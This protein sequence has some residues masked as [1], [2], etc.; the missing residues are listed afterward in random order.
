MLDCTDL[1]ARPKLVSSAAAAL[2]RGDIAVA[3][4]ENMYTLVCDAFSQR[5][6]DSAR[7]L[8]GNSKQ[9]LSVLVGRPVAVDGVA[10]NIPKYAR[11]LMAAFWPGPLT[12]LLRQ[13]PSL[14]WP[15]RAP[16]LAVRMPLHPLMLELTREVGPTAATSA[17][18]PGSPPISSHSDFED[19]LTDEVDLFLDAGL[20]SL[21]ERS[22]VVDAT[23]GNAPVLKRTGGVP[24]EA[25]AEGCPELG[26]AND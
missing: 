1:A 17:S 14:V 9:P 3:P 12:I 20:L 15:L 7:E 22:T 21:G 2:R 6:V 8:K 25:L 10:A 18:P 13:Q 11:D 23:D 26:Q 5:G 19:L 24:V 4:D 16:G